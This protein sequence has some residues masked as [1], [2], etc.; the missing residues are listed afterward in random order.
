M[1]DL[2]LRLTPSLSQSPNVS[3]DLLMNWYAETIEKRSVNGT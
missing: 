2:A 3:A 1:Y